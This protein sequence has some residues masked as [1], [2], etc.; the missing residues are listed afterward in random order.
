MDVIGYD[1]LV[2]GDFNRD[3]LVTA[4]DIVSM[5]TALADLNAYQ[6]AKNLTGPQMT[7]LG[8]LNGDGAV[9]NA[10]IQSLLDLVA[11][12]GGGSVASVPEPPS[13]ALLLLGV[14]ASTVIKRAGKKCCR[15]CQAFL[16]EYIRV[17][18]SPC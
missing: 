3:G 15:K 4:A 8:D 11:N 7:L 2:P 17:T 14:F 12:N 13:I 10:D 16:V 6:S 1:R 5:L 9:T 18:A